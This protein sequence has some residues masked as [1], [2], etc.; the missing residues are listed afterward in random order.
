MWPMGMG[1]KQENR[2]K[3]FP[4]ASQGLPLPGVWLAPCRCPSGHP[5]LHHLS[6]EP[7]TLSQTRSVAQ[8]FGRNGSLVWTGSLQGWAYTLVISLSIL[9]LIT[10][11][12]GFYLLFVKRE[13]NWAMKAENTRTLG[14]SPSFSPAL[15]VSL[16]A[17]HGQP[18]R[19]GG[20]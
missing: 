3:P 2:E 12:R 13:T 1:E 16:W 6:S 15:G 10:G 4:F 14:S 17:D 9:E 7:L 18:S 5:S 8:N 11:A 19:T 20:Y